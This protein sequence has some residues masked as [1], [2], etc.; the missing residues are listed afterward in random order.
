MP[1]ARSGSSDGGN[2]GT[3][4]RYCT[5]TVTVIVSSQEQRGA[6]DVQFNALGDCSR[7]DEFWRLRLEGAVT[8]AADG[9]TFA[10][11]SVVSEAEHL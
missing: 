10:S 5:R 8:V 4:H 9:S 7:E 11:E 1:A 6:K 3:L 2:D